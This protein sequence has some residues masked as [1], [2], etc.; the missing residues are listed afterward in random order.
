MHK[1]EK[2]ILPS[3]FF[4]R[5]TLLGTLVILRDLS[6]TSISLSLGIKP[7]LTSFET[8]FSQP[9]FWSQL[10]L[11]VPLLP[12]PKPRDELPQ[13]ISG[14]LL[15]P[16]LSFRWEESHIA[17]HRHQLLHMSVS[18]H[19]KTVGQIPAPYAGKRKKKKKKEGGRGKGKCQKLSVFFF[20]TL[21][22]LCF[23]PLPSVGLWYPTG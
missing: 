19:P 16:A 22:V 12:L 14:E 9:P 11:A 2:C 21:V 10:S 23:F 20:L 6:L 5:Y 17:S 7:P 13:S 3:L 4:L 8:E 18:I 15:P 1:G